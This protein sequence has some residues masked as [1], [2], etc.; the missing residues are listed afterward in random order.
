MPEIRTKKIYKKIKIYPISDF[1]WHHILQ[2]LGLLLPYKQ[3]N[4]I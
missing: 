3:G 1:K 2:K 4:T